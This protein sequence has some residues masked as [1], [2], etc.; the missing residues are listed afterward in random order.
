M[1]ERAVAMSDRPIDRLL[2]LSGLVKVGHRRALALAEQFMEEPSLIDPAVGAI[3]EIANR[4]GAD[5][6]DI[7]VKAIEDALQRYDPPILRRRAGEVVNQIQ[8]GE[9]FVNDW[10]VV[11][12]Y[13]RGDA[14][15]Q[16]LFDVAFPPE[17]GSELV[18]WALISI[19]DPGT[20]GVVDLQQAIGG[21]DRCAYLRTFIVADGDRPAR[22]EISSDDGVKVW[23]NGHV[24]HANNA[25]RG[26][27][28]GADRVDVE[29]REGRNDLM[30]KVTQGGGGW[31]MACRLRDPLGFHIDGT[32]FATAGEFTAGPPDSI[33]LLESG[34]N[35]WISSTGAAGWQ[36]EGD[37]I[38][39]VPGTGSIATVEHYQDF[40]LHVG[41]MIPEGR[42]GTGQGRANSGVY[43]QGRYEVQ[44]LDSAGDE[45]LA[46]GCGGIYERLAPRL[47]VAA[48]AGQ[49]QEY[50]IDFSAPGYDGQGQR[51]VPARIS[52][53]H[54]G[55]LIHDDVEIEGKTGLGAAEGPDP[56]PVVLQDHGHPIRFR[57]L[58][59]VARPPRWEGPGAPGFV[60]LFDGRTLSGW[61]Q[62]GGQAEYR[63]EDGQIVG[64]TRPHQPN[65]FLCTEQTY[66][67]FVLELEF[68]V[69]DAL[70]SGIQIRSN[71]LPEYRDGQVHGYQVE[72]DP[73]DRAWSAGIYDEGRR[74]WLAD[75]ED[76][77]RARGAFSHGAWNRL[78][79]VARGDEIRTWLNGVPAARLVDSTTPS[80]FI[81]LQ[82]H[83]VGDRAEPLEVR[84]RDLRLRSQ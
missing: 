84:W 57:D 47:N 29:L 67:D 8:A 42:G 23:L 54:N 24:V 39:V 32:R 19:T 70:N 81:G 65:S 62:L 61:R 3:I 10:L 20:P 2:V 12:P 16:E 38:V 59:V 4:I 72:I 1:Y 58:W 17:A 25:L 78:R 76:N 64:S 41:F 60:P 31:A 35:T 79:I 34:L 52:V 75:L 55:V 13:A 80:G 51:V 71:S 68:K 82:V 33:N 30:I 66:G 7:A 5:E 40:V 27:S 45:P 37:E 69:D 56:G 46:D 83:G 18:P 50:L 26:L 9:D 49:W 74:G 14:G 44:I 11:G 22:L 36:I 48:E 43:L 73:S 28:A 53:W 77:P 21:G 15:P 63:A 6:P